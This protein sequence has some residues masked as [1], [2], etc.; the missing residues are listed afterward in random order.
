[1]AKSGE[2]DDRPVQCACVTDP[3]LSLPPELR[4][5][6]RK[7]S[8]RKVTCLGCGLVYWMNRET[9]L[10]GVDEQDPGAEAD[11]G[12]VGLVTV[13]STLAGYVFGLVLA[14]V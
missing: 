4:P 12:Y 5:R 6:P 3:F 8:L 10:Y 13:F 1:M 11:R 9:G 7:S 2:R 14:V